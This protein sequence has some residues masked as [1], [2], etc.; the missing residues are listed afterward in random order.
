MPQ[1]QSRENG[2]SVF[3]FPLVLGRRRAIRPR[4]CD[5]F[6]AIGSSLVVWPAVGFLLMAKHCGGKLVIINIEATEQDDVADHTADDDDPRSHGARLIGQHRI[7][8]VLIV[9]NSPY[10]QTQVAKAEKA[11]PHSAFLER[12]S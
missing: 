9:A 2:L 6:L 12:L 3:R 4:Q 5:L 10:R 7:I 11:I 8:D 1:R